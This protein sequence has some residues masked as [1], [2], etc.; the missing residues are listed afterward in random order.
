MSKKF[1]RYLYRHQAAQLIALGCIAAL[2]ASVALSCSQ[3]PTVL[4]NPEPRTE[5]NQLTIRVAIVR[6]RTIKILSPAAF[7]ICDI[8]GKSPAAI[9]DTPYRI[10]S[11]SAIRATPGGISIGSELVPM[12]ACR[13]VPQTPYPIAVYEVEEHWYYGEL[14]LYRNDDGTI[15]V[16]NEVGLEDYL[17][18]VLGHEVGA[19]WPVEALRAQAVASRTRV[20]YQREVARRSG[21]RFDVQSDIRDQVYGGVPSGPRSRKLFEAVR[22]TAG[23]VLT[24]N[25]LIF[26]N[27][28]SSTCGG[29]TEHAVSVFEEDPGHHP[30]GGVPCPYCKSSPVHTWKHRVP[31][32]EVQKRIRQHTTDDIGEII[33]IR[34]LN[35]DD[36]GHGDPVEVK[37]TKGATVFPDANKFRTTV[38][39][40]G[41]VQFWKDG[42][43]HEASERP[44]HREFI[45]STSF[46][47]RIDGDTVEFSGRGWGHAVGM[48]QYG[49]KG[50]AEAGKDYREILFYYYPGARIAD[51]YH[52]RPATAGG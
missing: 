35:P 6:G 25:N 16:V 32:A 18:G 1:L 19:S 52:L 29:M 28:F 39:G 41:R 48:C 17:A 31:K 8:E 38:L 51:N 14:Y 10:T 34:V 13:I 3:G 27:Y 47:A 50:M 7:H 22:A 15:D 45:M 24:Y 20:L 30:P 9:K 4:Y 5:E 26:K 40:R 11:V 2:L 44:I 49:A 21:Q 43:W 36:A 46:T 12:K 33:S 42:G 23:E 37:H